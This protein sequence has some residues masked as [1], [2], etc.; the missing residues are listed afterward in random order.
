[1][2]DQGLLGQAK[3]AG[4]TNTLLYGA[5][6]DSS[7]SA[8][9]TIANDGTGAAYDVAIKNYDQAL[10]L[11]ASSYL[12]HEGDV[13]TGYR[14]TLG[15][16]IDSN[17]NLVPSNTITSA[18]GEKTAQF[19]SFYV[20][21]FT[22]I[23]VK[24]VAIRAITVE[25]VSGTFAIG[26]TLTKGSSPNNTDAL[27]YAVVTGESNTIIHIGPSTLNGTGTEFADG[28]SVSTAGGASATVST[29]G[30]G[31]A[32][33]EFVFSTDGSTYNLF[34]GV[35]LT[36]F[37]DRSYRFDTSDSS[38]SGRDFS[39]ST[40]INGEWGPD[41]TAGTEDD[42]SEYTTGKTTNGTAGSGGAYVQF[43]FSADPNLG[44]TLYFY[45]G[46]TGTASNANFGGTDRFL[47][48][49]TDFTYNEIYVYELAGTWANSSDSFTAG[50]TSF[51]LTGQTAGPY[52]Y[53]RSYSSTTLK[54][55]KGTGS[56]DFAGTNVFQDSPKDGTASRSIVT[57]S[58]VDVATTAVGVE[59]FISKDKTNAANNVDKL[60]SLVI[61]PGERLIVESATQNNVF[62]LLGFEDASNAFTVRNF[63]ESSAGAG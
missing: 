15:T 40:T 25:S 50:G 47:S 45:D 6:I 4:T 20:P 16:P 3:P 13:I 44:T 8:V 38:M 26:D 43:D 52:G 55:I 29:G 58:S 35:D 36:I 7:A 17:S 12:L 51:T 62:T 24:N 61:G 11:D 5:P 22:E 31:S 19:E 53:V 54:V 32:N 39:F 34:L 59:N 30:V 41:N 28:D 33:N 63:V 23:D 46:G 27:V 1:M 57:V 10:T 48:L 60:T 18:D 9:L 49:S 37:K 2:A 14:F 56:A 42:G 21:P